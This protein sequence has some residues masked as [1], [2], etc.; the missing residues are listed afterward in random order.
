MSLAPRR[1][2][3]LVGEEDSSTPMKTLRLVVADDHPVVRAGLEAML[4]TQP[5]FELVGNASTVSEASR[6]IRNASP[7][8]ALVDLRMP[9]GSGVDVISE[10]R[11]ER[12]PTRIIVLTT[13]GGDAN[14]TRALDAGANGYLLKDAPP[15]ELFACIRRVARGETVVAPPLTE[16]LDSRVQSPRDT[17]SA[18]ELEV[19]VWLARGE[20][21]R[22][23]ARRLCISEATV[24]T[25]LI[26]IFSKLGQ[27]HRTAV[28]TE[29]LRRGLIRLEGEAE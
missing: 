22:G 27:N 21:N 12:L 18:R 29:A 19:L 9:G 3:T 20:T 15:E 14:V 11:R 16:T 2:D 28:V 26:H 23:I 10:A 6:C 4:R 17:L 7:H 13:Y 8:V 1:T 25:H 24:K 5:D